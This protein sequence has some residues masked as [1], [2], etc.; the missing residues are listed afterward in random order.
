LEIRHPDAVRP[1]QH[2]LEPLAG[3][4][5]LA[6]EL[7]KNSN[8]AGAYNFGPE[9]NAAAS[10]KDVVELARG[11]FGDASVRYLDNIEGPHEAGLLILDTEK[12][13]VQLGVKPRLNLNATVKSTIDWYIAQKSGVDARELCLENIASYEESQ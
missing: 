6:E 9:A 2:V 4:L 3:Y 10:V 8:L 7:W 12:S 13:R 11:C 1:W 5:I